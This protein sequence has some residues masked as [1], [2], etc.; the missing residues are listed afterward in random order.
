MLT[1]LPFRVPLERLQE[2]HIRIAGQIGV[3]HPITGSPQSEIPNYVHLWEQN[4]LA[5]TV[6]SSAEAGFHDAIRARAP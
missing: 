5:R 2:T 3:K 4:T 1:G 6:A